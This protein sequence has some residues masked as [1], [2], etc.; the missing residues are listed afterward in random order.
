MDEENIPEKGRML[1]ISAKHS[2]MQQY[3]TP[4][5]KVLTK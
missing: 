4:I 1:V 5:I 3:A 2:M